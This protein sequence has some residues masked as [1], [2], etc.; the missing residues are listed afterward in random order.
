ML[1]ADMSKNGAVLK[2]DGVWLTKKRNDAVD[3][4]VVYSSYVFG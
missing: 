2:H 1:C 3:L 4:N